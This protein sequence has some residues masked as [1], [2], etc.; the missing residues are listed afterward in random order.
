MVFNK[1]AML[2]NLI[3]TFVVVLVGLS[4]I[5]MIAQEVDNVVNCQ[6]YFYENSTNMTGTP[7]GPTDSFGG[8]GSDYHFGGY[9]GKVAHKSFLSQYSI[10]QTN[11]SMLNPDCKPMSESAKTALGFIPIIFGIVIFFIG[12]AVAHSSLRNIGII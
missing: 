4:L 10:I 6:L 8:G 12:I 2:G 1:K 3:G 9:D 11:S 7:K 5:P